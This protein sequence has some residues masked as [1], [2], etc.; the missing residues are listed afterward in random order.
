MTKSKN[1]FRIT[2]RKLNAKSNEQPSATSA[3][4]VDKEITAK[5][6]LS[7]ILDA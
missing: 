3:V 6:L 1:N 2:V 7:Y 4:F 5:E